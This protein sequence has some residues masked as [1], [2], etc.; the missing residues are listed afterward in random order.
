MSDDQQGDASSSHEWRIP[1][2][3]QIQTDAYHVWK[4]RPLLRSVH[5]KP[6]PAPP[7]ESAAGAYDVFI[8]QR[9]LRAVHEQLWTA[10]PDETPFGFLIGDLCEDPDT[11]RRYVIV[12]RTMPSRFPLHEE[13]P[14]QIPQ[15]ALMALELEADRRRGVLAGWYH[16]HR[17]GP[18]ALTAA[19]AATHEKHFAEPW[20]IA[21]LF[22][23]EH[24]DPS[25]G[26]FR[27]SR[28]GLIQDQPLAFFE[29]VSNESLLA[30]GVRRSYIDWAN[31]ETVDSI[32]LEPLPRPA[33][34]PAP[35]EPDAV[36]DPTTGEA[37]VEIAVE[38]LAE[39]VETEV[40]DFEPEAPVEDFEDFED[41]VEPTDF[42]EEVEE[43]EDFEEVVE[44][45]L[46][47]LE[48]GAEVEDLEPEAEL[49]GFEEEVSAQVEDF[50]PEAPVEDFE[51]EVGA[52][53]F[54]EEVEALVESLQEEPE[55]E[56][57]YF[58]EELEPLVESPEEQAEVE[59]FEEE[60]GAQIGDFAEEVV[61]LVESLEEEAEAE[62]ED[63]AE[64][65]ETLVASLEE[66][67]KAGVEDLE[68]EAELEDFEREVSAQ[69]EDLEEE[70][71]Q[72]EGFDE[73]P[74]APIEV[75]D[76]ELGVA[77]QPSAGDM[78]ISSLEFAT[79]SALDLELPIETLL[80]E[81]LEETEE[82]PEVRAEPTEEEA[83]IDVELEVLEGEPDAWHEAVELDGDVTPDGAGEESDLAEI[84]IPLAD[85]V[86]E[87][88]REPTPATTV[89]AP[90]FELG[91]I[92]AADETLAEPAWDDIGTAAEQPE[93]PSIDEIDLESFVTEV[94]SADI[95]G[96]VQ[97]D[98]T[99]IEPSWDAPAEA[100]PDPA[101]PVTPP[102]TG[103]A[104]EE[105][106]GLALEEPES[107]EAEPA[108]RAERDWGRYRRGL[109]LAGGIVVAVAI[110][111][112]LLTFLRPRGQPEAGS[113]GPDAVEP[114][115]SLGADDADGVTAGAEGD[116]A[117]T[118]PPPPAEVDSVP[119]EA[120]LDEVETLG[121][122]LLESVSRYYGLAVA[123][124]EGRAT[125]TQLREAYAEV[126]SRWI[127]YNLEGKARFRGRLTEEL[128]SRDER[129][130][131]G[132]R[133][134]ERE[135]GRSGCERP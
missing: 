14:E 23:M 2:E 110:I 104:P 84:S 114:P 65:V 1:E 120:T 56:S 28:A 91:E 69:I 17:R 82:E 78:P 105:E 125:C 118:D 94:E 83:E 134:V 40:E 113:S 24:D 107:D 98:L 57:E 71:V 50:E 53:D 42:E 106:A 12:T 70:T 9:V 129:L 111:A 35:E 32:L 20:Q 39:A 58:E 45:E 19:D 34:P 62:V 87:T 116:A 97:T 60:V 33:P 89:D 119:S 15:A 31:V 73:E 46:K 7:R 79:D 133:D 61:V 11:T 80:E 77:E 90:A 13:G 92:Q 49:E 6:V 75:P 81:K 10:Q 44:A 135:F 64:E 29:M 72:V 96:Q 130:Y 76:H 108:E 112:S 16:G 47:D 85:F 100:Q 122:G 131:D 86:T 55:A 59:D 95:T 22:V 117:R 67:G 101:L 54:A 5:W 74:V 121:D 27:W 4:P 8:E 99:T 132:V 102:P 3:E 21:L 109:V 37:E 88:D 18:V 127:D 68:P 26:C 128:A 38:D 48:P 126:E 41:E 115:V 36:V 30:Q 25:G 103:P 66:E 52:E 43:V 63:F 123:R 124:D 51:D 93:P